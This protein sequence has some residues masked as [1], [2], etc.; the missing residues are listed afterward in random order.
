[1]PSSIIDNIERNTVKIDD[2][3]VYKEIINKSNFNYKETNYFKDLNFSTNYSKE[4]N[5]IKR[6]MKLKENCEPNN[7][8]NEMEI[9]E[10]TAHKKYF[11]DNSK[12]TLKDLR[13]K[14]S[15][16]LNQ[17]AS[18]N[19][20]SKNTHNFQ[21]E[22]EL[23]R[24]SPKNIENEESFN[25][26]GVNIND[27]K[28]IAD[29]FN[30]VV[31]SEVKIELYKKEL[32]LR[33]DFNLVDLFMFFDKEKKG[34]CTLENFI[35]TLKEFGIK[36]KDKDSLLFFRRFDRN[37]CK[38]LKFSDFSDAFCPLTK[39]NFNLLNQRKPINNDDKF[40]LKEVLFFT[41]MS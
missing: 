21:E 22:N 28:E 16:Y 17:N 30:F 18:P 27:F 2:A 26:N 23:N 10:N 25:R 6:E 34:Y 41:A 38:F 14:Y 5:H 11:V 13:S 7:D 33:P 15:K 24:R 19:F 4:N 1:M 40:R 20:S 39:E 35:E 3:S 31:N 12:T 29:F 32:S 36:A 8:D 37:D 9:P